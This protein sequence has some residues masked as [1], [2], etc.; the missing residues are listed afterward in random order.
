MTRNVLSYLKDIL[1]NMEDTEEF[2]CGMSYE[3]FVADKRTFNAVL[4]RE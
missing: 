1:Q 3:Q 4:E 2:I